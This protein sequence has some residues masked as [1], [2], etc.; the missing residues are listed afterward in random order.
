MLSFRGAKTARNLPRSDAYR[1]YRGILAVFHYVPLHLSGFGRRYGGKA[2]DYPVTEDV[3][4]RL[5]RLPFFCA[6]TDTEQMRVIEAVRQFK[7]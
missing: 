3:S 6:L 1:T 2:G 5:L 7:P 4:D